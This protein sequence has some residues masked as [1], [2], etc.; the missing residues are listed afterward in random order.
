MKK[1]F[2][3]LA[4]AALLGLMGCQNADNTEPST[5]NSNDQAANTQAEPTQTTEY[6]STA[7][8][9]ATPGLD[10]SITIDQIEWEIGSTINN[11]NREVTLN[12]TNNSNFTIFEI[13]IEFVQK[14]D[15][16]KDQRNEAFADMLE[17][18]FY[19][20]DVNEDMYLHAY[21]RKFAEPGASVDSG[22]CSISDIRPVDSTDQFDLFEPDLM[23]IAYLGGDGNAYIEYYDFVNDAY[24]DG[25]NGGHP[26][27]EWSD[28]DIA[29]L[30]P[31]M[32]AP[33]VVKSSDDSDYFS[34]RAGGVTREDYDAYVDACKQ[35]GFT[36]DESEYDNSYG[37]SN[38]DRYE[39][40][41]YW[42][43][44]EDT[45]SVTIDG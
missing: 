32:D 13:D 12:Y 39:V 11:G 29:K 24:S 6:E 16:T 42:V 40:S 20:D 3:T 22:S 31:T 27:V 9:G 30:L 10:D 23:T 34:F 26:A 19:Q 1:I 7:N 37:A 41:I 43:E 33:I 14:E 18:E 35:A 36:E 28:S 21:N 17:N 38:A 15:I 5:N 2:I 4:F 45:I 25:S 44:D 8:N